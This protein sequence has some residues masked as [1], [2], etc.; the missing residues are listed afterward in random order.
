MTKDRAFSGSIILFCF[1]MYAATFNFAR[2]SATTTDPQV[3]PRAII[4][5]ITVLAL[6]N[7]VISFFSKSAEPARAF[8]FRGFLSRY[9]KVMILFLMFFVYAFI[10]PLIG[11]VAA[12]LL[13]MFGTQGLLMGVKRKKALLINC[14]VSVTSAVGVYYIFTEALNIILP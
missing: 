10:L 14:I 11:F 6:A 3:F 7:L 5:I 4:L 1:V 12:T 8:D 2:S 9:T 13:F